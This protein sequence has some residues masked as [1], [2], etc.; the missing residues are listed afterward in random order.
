MDTKYNFI[1]D[2][3]PTDEQLAMIMSEATKSVIQKANE[4]K[5]LFDEQFN[6]Y[7][8]ETKNKYQ[9]IIEKYASKA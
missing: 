4:A 1:S 6:L 9:K 3:E 5:K 7:L 8:L 2:E